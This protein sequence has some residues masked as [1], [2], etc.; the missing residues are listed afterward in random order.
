MYKPDILGLFHPLILTHFHKFL[1]HIGHR[2]KPVAL[3]VLRKPQHTLGAYARN[4]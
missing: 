2:K 1:G 3:N 4:P